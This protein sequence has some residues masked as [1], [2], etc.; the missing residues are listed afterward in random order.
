V[1]V[2]RQTPRLYEP[3]PQPRP[4]LRVFCFPYAG[5]G[6]GMFRA[7]AGRLGADVE[8]AGIRLPGRESRWSET[9]H[10]DW[11]HAVADAVETLTARLDRPYVLFGH[12]FG[13]MLAYEVA[14][15]IQLLGLQLP[16]ALV[17]SG[18]RSPQIAP[19]S[20]TPWNAPSETLWRW[21]ADMEGTPA[22]VLADEGLREAFEPVLR[23]D[24][25]LAEVWR[26]SPEVALD[27]PIVTFGAADDPVAPP[28]ALEGWAD[29]GARGCERVEF[30]GGHFFLHASEAAVLARLAD[31]CAASGAHARAA[32]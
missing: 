15:A 17:L 24:L 8:V 6:P 11:P 10:R 30:A 13:A 16:R 21:V 23:A 7:W 31:V 1:S 3:A 9:P 5:A 20:D 28:W 25:Q 26:N 19:V 22:G 2:A 14:R 32:C 29:F 12:S 27:V 18:C 4:A